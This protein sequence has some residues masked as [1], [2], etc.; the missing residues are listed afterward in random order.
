MITVLVFI[1][2][3]ALIVFFYGIM[4]KN[5]LAA[6]LGICALALCFPAYIVIQHMAAE[7]TGA[8]YAEIQTKMM[9]NKEYRKII[10]Q[11]MENGKLT[12]SQLKK[13]N[14]KY[15]AIILKRERKAFLEDMENNGK[16][17][18]RYLVE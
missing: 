15:D 14:D 7:I 2:A 17:T 18:N 10:R 13:A 11:N 9:Q 12:N 8:E 6:F 5:E 1:I 3:M 16:G 4:E